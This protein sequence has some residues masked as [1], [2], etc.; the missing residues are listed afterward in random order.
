[1]IAIGCERF[2][3]GGF[4]ASQWVSSRPLLFVSRARTSAEQGVAN[5]EMFLRTNDQRIRPADV[6]RRFAARASASFGETR[7]QFSARG[8]IAA[9]QQGTR[10]EFHEGCDDA[11]QEAAQVVSL[12]P[13]I[14]R[15][16]SRLSPPYRCGRTGF[17]T[18]SAPPGLRVATKLAGHQLTEVINNR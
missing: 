13:R 5:C 17:F 9:A 4:Y 3:K 2:L 14:I 8:S 11:R 7:V 10:Q 16:T 12:T 18:R 1:M 6:R 15:W